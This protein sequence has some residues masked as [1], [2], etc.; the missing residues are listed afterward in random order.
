M[1]R[2][3]CVAARATLCERMQ[4]D[5]E[6]E[7]ETGIPVGQ[8]GQALET[9][10]EAFPILAVDHRSRCRQVFWLCPASFV[11][12]ADL[13]ILDSAVTLTADRNQLHGRGE[14]DRGLGFS[15][16]RRLGNLVTT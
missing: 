10:G 2:H 12:Y 5:I 4:I 1:D 13:K 11:G 14:S 16:Q 8:V 9:Q 7:L 15:S 6:T 3:N